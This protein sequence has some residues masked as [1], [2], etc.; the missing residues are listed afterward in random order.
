MSEIKDIP[1]FL[2]TGFLEGGKTKFLQETLEDKRFNSGERTLLIVCEAGTRYWSPPV[3][4]A[5][6]IFCQEAFIMLIEP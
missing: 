1:V 2:F 6:S 5:V 4:R 3:T